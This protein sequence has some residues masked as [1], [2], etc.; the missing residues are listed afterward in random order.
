LDFAYTYLKNNNVN[1][2]EVDVPAFEK[3]SGVGVVVT[4]DDVKKIV[5]DFLAARDKEV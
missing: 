4:E 5:A 2:K 1:N 3:A